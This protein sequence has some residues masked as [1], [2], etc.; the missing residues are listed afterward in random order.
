MKELFD[1]FGACLIG[2][3]SAFSF[4]CGENMSELSGF[5]QHKTVKA[6]EVLWEEGAPSDYVAIISSGKIEIKKKTEFEGKHV[7]VG[8]YSQG[9]VVGTLGI[10]N[11]APRAATAV[12]LEDVTL[13]ILTPENFEKLMQKNPDLGIRLLKGM[14]LSVSVRLK[15]SFE[16][17]SKFF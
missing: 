1:E 13:L 3:N 5:F 17:L 2:E 11:G 14:L 16:R 4:L 7:V 10:L 12:A 8:I 9:A 6:G 15:K